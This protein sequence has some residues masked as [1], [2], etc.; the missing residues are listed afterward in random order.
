MLLLLLRSGIVLRLMLHV[1][2]LLL[3]VRWLGREV[4]LIGRY[5]HDGVAAALHLW[6]HLP[7][8][9]AAPTAGRHV[10][11]DGGHRY[12]GVDRGGV[13]A[14]LGEHPA[15][16][17]AADAVHTGSGADVRH[18]HLVVPGERTGGTGRHER[19]TV[20]LLHWRV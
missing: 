3:V 13:G 12:R 11:D 2:L 14:A 19:V 16:R 4:V 6:V 10:G 1:R 17:V 9:Y 8:V 15:S 18:G 5:S 20:G 7:A